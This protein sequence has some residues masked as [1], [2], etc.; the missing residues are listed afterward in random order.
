MGLVFE[1]YSTGLYGPTKSYAGITLQFLH[2]ESNKNYYA[3][4]N[5]EVTRKRRV[6]T[7]T[8]RHDVGARLP[9]GHFR[10]GK[11]SGFYAFWLATDLK[12]PPR[13][14]SF[15]D[16]MGNLR[17]ITFSAEVKSGNK[18]RSQTIRPWF[19]SNVCYPDSEPTDNFR[20][21]PIQQTP[22]PG[23]VGGGLL[24]SP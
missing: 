9:K 5:A 20:T 3:I 4:F 10:V 22:L 2:I 19:E 21:S 7:N 6:K 12:I 11:R 23:S 17:S 24:G 14:S 8:G 16:Y 15:H 1:S 18:L 13:L